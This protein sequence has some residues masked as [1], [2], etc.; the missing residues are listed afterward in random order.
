MAFPKHGMVKT[1][2]YA[3]YNAMKAR[4]NNVNHPAYSRY[5]G[6]GIKVCDE[7]NI[8]NG[9]ENFLNDMGMKPN[10]KSTLERKNNSGDYTPENCSWSDWKIQNRNRRNTITVIVN[11]EEISIAALAEAIGM[12]YYTLWNRL[13]LYN[14]SVEKAV[15]QSIY[16]HLIGNK[17]AESKLQ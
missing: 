15:G 16:G 9:F 2:E 4:C 17:H 11:G 7:W 5:G 3:A 6:R 10:P 12:N 14:W 1:S 8:S 13:Q